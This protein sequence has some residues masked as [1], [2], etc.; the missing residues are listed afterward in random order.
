MTNIDKNNVTLTGEKEGAFYPSCQSELLRNVR[1]KSPYYLK[2]GILSQNLTNSGGGT[3][4]GPVLA[5]SEVTLSSS[6]GKKEPLRFLS[7]ISATISIS[8]EEEAKPL[9]ESVIGSML[10]AALIVRGDVVSDMVKLENALIFGNVRGRQITVVNSIIIGSLMAE[11]E[12]LVENSKFVSFAGGHVVLK[13]NNGCWLPYGTSLVPIEFEDA[14]DSRGEKISSQLHY[15]AIKNAR[16]KKSKG[17]WSGNF[18]GGTGDDRESADTALLLGPADIK[19][20]KTR[21]G[22]DIYTL[23]I[24]RRALNLA[25][26]EKEIR[27]IEEFLK[28]ILMYEHLDKSSRERERK[29]WEKKFGTEELGLLKYTLDLI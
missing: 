29:E 9:A 17:M 5:S 21:D 26:V 10:K 8:M 13:G 7:G 14:V 25:P 4:T 28:G 11:D 19:K 18:T 24:A 23:N 22:K 12:L 2:G 3:V 27:A 16:D 1:L 6:T 20:H 15:L